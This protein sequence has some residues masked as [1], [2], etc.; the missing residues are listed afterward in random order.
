[1]PEHQAGF[2]T[3]TVDGHSL[4]VTPDH[5]FDVKDKGW[6]DAADLAPG[7]LLRTVGGTWSAVQAIRIEPDP[8]HWPPLGFVAGTP[9]L[10]AGWSIP[11]EDLRPGD[12][13]DPS[14]DD[15]D[16]EPDDELPPWYWN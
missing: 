6:T 9:I 5:P 16:A 8:R 15:P 4:R 7:D 10:S 11:I 1:M 14:P 3:I 13:I 2:I 12:L